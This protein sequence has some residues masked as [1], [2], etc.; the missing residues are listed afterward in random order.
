MRVGQ[1]RE[2]AAA[3]IAE[4][5]CADRDFRGAYASGSTVG[6]PDDAE[7]SPYSDLDVCV[8]TARTDPPAAP[9]KLRHR[10]ALLEVSHVP[11]SQVAS[12]E[13]VL[14]T[15]YLA[16]S[17]RG[18]SL[19]ADP[20]GRLAHVQAR[21]SRDFARQPWVRR[22]CADARGRIESRLAGAAAGGMPFH[23]QVTAPTRGAGNGASN[24]PPAGG[25][26]T[27]ATAPPGR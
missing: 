5:A 15:Y 17:F 13:K 18:G 4:H 26:Y 2:A 25:P 16:G 10:G 12:A 27:T 8:V 24:R 11:W 1:A 9:G 3:W 23:E 19:L 22:R 14:A 7:L 6:L 21:V 20:T